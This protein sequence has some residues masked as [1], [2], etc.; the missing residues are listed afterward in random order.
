MLIGLSLHPHIY[1]CKICVANHLYTTNTSRVIG[2]Q[3]HPYQTIYQYVMGLPL[4]P[5][6]LSLLAAAC[7]AAASSSALHQMGFASLPLCVA[8][9]SRILA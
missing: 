4:Y 8:S 5:R 9:F 1:H 2:L 3:H 7:F 6:A